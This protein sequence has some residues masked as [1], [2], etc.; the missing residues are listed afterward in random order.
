MASIGKVEIVNNL[1]QKDELKKL[2]EV[3]N[4]N[5]FA[6]Y[7]QKHT[8]LEKGVEDI[9]KYM[10][11][12]VLHTPT[13]DNN[14]VFLKDFDIIPLKLCEKY[15]FNKTLRMKLNLYPNQKEKVFHESHHDY[16]IKEENNPEE[17]ITICIF[18]F[19]TCNGG[20]VINNKSYPSIE[21]QAIL[22]PNEY[23][24]HGFTATDV[25]SRVLLNIG[26]K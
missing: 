4:L 5:T 18:N 20:T 26:L 17:D 13:N 15:G 24:H 8:S 25:Q 9:D 1:L 21:N 16:Y 11:T 3:L 10:F 23:K 19:T 7:F 22:F 2:Q 6:W 12:H 14:S